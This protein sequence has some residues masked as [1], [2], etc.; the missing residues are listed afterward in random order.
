MLQLF[1]KNTVIKYKHSDI[2]LL[3]K[4]IVFYFKILKNVIYSSAEFQQQLF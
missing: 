4:I 1:D 2:L 3:F